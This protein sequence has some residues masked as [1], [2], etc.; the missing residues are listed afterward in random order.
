[1]IVTR[2]RIREV[3]IAIFIESDTNRKQAYYVTRNIA[4]YR[5]HINKSKGYQIKQRETHVNEQVT[6]RNARTD[7]CR[8]MSNLT[9]TTTKLKRFEWTVI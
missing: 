7:M 5:M 9:I 4:Q 2:R 1:M 3:Q 8:K 6:P